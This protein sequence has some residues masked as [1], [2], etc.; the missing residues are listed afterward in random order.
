M[1][2]WSNGLSI[3]GTVHARAENGHAEGCEALKAEHLSIFDCAVAGKGKRFIA[4]EAHLKMMAAAQP[5]LSGAI[6]KTV[7]LPNSSKPPEVR[8][9][10]IQAWKLGLKSLAVYRDGSKVSQP[11][12]AIVCFDCG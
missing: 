8:E 3:R 6:S 4:P 5:F 11:L 10:F 7:N 1:V 9:L 2:L 12:E